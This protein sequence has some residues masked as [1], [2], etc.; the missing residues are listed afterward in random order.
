MRGWEDAD[1]L[2]AMYGHSNGR[3]STALAMVSTHIVE[4][5]ARQLH[6][7]GCFSPRT[8]ACSLMFTE[9]Y[10]GEEDLFFSI[11]SLGY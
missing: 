8:T 4:K 7:F 3:P 11:Q 1:S 10:L 5:W 6:R 2:G 9:R